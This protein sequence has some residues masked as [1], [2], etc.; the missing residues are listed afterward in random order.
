MYIYIYMYISMSMNIFGRNFAQFLEAGGLGSDC[1]VG[2][3]KG[4]GFDYPGISF[5][6]GAFMMS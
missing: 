5:R 6:P 4:P 3:S 1:K 2:L